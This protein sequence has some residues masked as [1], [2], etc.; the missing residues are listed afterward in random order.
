MTTFSTL[1]LDADGVINDGKLLSLQ[2]DFGI[3]PDR[4]AR[5]FR[6]AFPACMVGKADLRESIVPYLEEWGWKGDADELLDYWFKQGDVVRPGVRSIAERLKDA[7]ISLH[8]AT[9][10]EKRRVHYMRTAMGYGDLFDGMHTSSEIGFMKPSLDFFAAA[11]KRM[12][13]PDPSTVLFWDDME[14]N[15]LAA[16]DYGFAAEVF[17][18]EED[19]ERKM[20]EYFPL[21]G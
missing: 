5:F 6:E 17:T 15:V 16:R 14:K 8:L 10:Q 11:H 19:F 12:G 2:E 4:M 3:V 1:L 18:T 13:E 9:N 21:L 7:G 20:K